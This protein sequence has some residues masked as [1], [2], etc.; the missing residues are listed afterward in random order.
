MRRKVYEIIEVAKDGQVASKVYDIV[1]MVTI[2]VSILPLAFKS[3]TPFFSVV[4]KVTV[5]M[6]KITQK[7]Y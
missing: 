4:D 6:I 1:M 7:R 2:I 5:S 3:E